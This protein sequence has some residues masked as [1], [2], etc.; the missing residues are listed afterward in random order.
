MHRLWSAIERR[1]ALRADD[2]SAIV[3]AG[4]SASVTQPG[5]TGTRGR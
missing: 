5:T 3:C 1:I 2:A 4:V